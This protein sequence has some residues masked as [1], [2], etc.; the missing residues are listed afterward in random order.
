M[1]ALHRLAHTPSISLQAGDLTESERLARR[2]FS[3]VEQRGFDKLGELV[4]P[5]ILLVSKIR[6]GHVVEGRDDFV[7]FVEE[8][9][10]DALH[11]A[12]PSAYYPLDDE[13]IV[14]EGRIRWIDEDRVIRDDPIMWAMEF[15]DGMVRRFVAARSRIE[16]ENVLALPAD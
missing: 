12:L 9:L 5:S 6:P 16:A 1:D 2:W 11:K 13:R 15:E 14:V 10:A 8:T 7:R 4:H 3:L